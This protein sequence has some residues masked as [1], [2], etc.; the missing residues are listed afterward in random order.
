[1]L[2]DTSIEVVLGL[3]FFSFSNADAEFVEL[4]KLNWRFYIA[5]EALSTTS[6]VELINKREFAKAALDKNSEIFVM[7]VATLE[8]TIIHSSQAA[9]IAAL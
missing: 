2:A 5:A 9:Q 8:A 4:G 3:P 7:H 6:W 1:M